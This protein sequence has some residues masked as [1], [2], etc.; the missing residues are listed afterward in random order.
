M[1]VP[2]QWMESWAARTEGHSKR[3]ESEAREMEVT[4]TK[5]D[6]FYTHT[7]TQYKI[8]KKLRIIKYI[9]LNINDFISHNMINLKGF[10]NALERTILLI[11]IY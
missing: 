6:F 11:S 9:S 1:Q 7:H 2:R 8:Q 5:S 4:I 3:K 10:R